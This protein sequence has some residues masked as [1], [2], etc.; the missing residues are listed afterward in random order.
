M[1]VNAFVAQFPDVRVAT[2]K[3]NATI[4][5]LY[6]RLSMQGGVFNIQFVKDPDYF[7]FL[8]YEGPEHFVLLIENSEGVAEGMA[9]LVMRPGYVGDDVEWVGH[10]SDLRFIRGRDRRSRFDWKAF[11][12]AVCEHGHEVEGWHGCKHWLG[13]F[14]MA[15][16]RARAAFTAQ[17]TP[18]DIT[19]VASYQMVNLLAHRPFGRS[20]LRQ[21]RRGSAVHVRKANTRDIEALRSFLDTQSRKRALGYV[22]EGEYDE[23]SRRLQSWDD[24][25]IESF[26]LA[27]D[28]RGKLLGCFAPWD[29]SPGRRIVVDDFPTSVRMAAGVA[30]G[31]GK[32]VPKPGDELRIL[33]LTTQE[34]D[35]TLSPSDRRAVFA[36]LLEGLYGDPRVGAYHMVAL[37]DYDRET[38]LDVVDPAY[39]TQKTP[40]LLYAMTA[41]GAAIPVNEAH[42]RV[43]AGHEM[44]LT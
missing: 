44:C 4:L 17:D 13:S 15:N 34:I 5:E 22:Y 6:R 26:Y 11:M 37:T 1:D 43:H 16:E 32:A 19:N 35:H 23:L 41:P 29:L 7:R 20:K 31:L 3:D 28:D 25:S 8:R 2:E 24:F 39:F 14:V 27:E 40:T 33:Y 9:T 10:W 36:A 12:A 38:L 21:L 30:R 42:L 18:F